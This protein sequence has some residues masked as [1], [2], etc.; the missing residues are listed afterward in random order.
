VS[1]GDRKEFLHEVKL[2]KNLRSEYTMSLLA[3]CDEPGRMCYVMP[4]MQNGDLRRY[5]DEHPLHAAQQHHIASGIAKGL[6]YLHHNG[7]VHRD[8][9]SA[10]VLLDAHL[11]P[12]M[13]DFGLSNRDGQTN[14]SLNR[15]TDDIQWVAPEVLQGQRPNR[16]SDVYSFGTVLWELFTGQKPF[17]NIPPHELMRAAAVRTPYQETLPDSIPPFYK[18]LI[19]RCWA[20]PYHRP[21]MA[22]V[23][24][25]LNTYAKARPELESYHSLPLGQSSAGPASSTPPPLGQSASGFFGPSS[26]KALPP[27]PGA[28]PASPIIARM[29]ELPSLQPPSTQEELADNLF[30]A[31]CEHERQQQL[32]KAATCYQQA[33]HLGHMRAKTNLGS[34]Y[35]EGKGNLPQDFTKAAHLFEEAAKLGHPRAM[36]NLSYCYETGQGVPQNPLKASEW[37]AKASAPQAQ[38][39]SP[40]M[41]R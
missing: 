41:R 25:T 26:S 10:N 12:K 8:V 4:Y 1:E 17:A 29:P 19:A 18:A 16:A 37:K 30:A 21:H 31:G 28:G 7:I 33:S 39:P 23:V 34:F 2:M 3:A 15:R 40:A 5:L 9:K 22:E 14:N 36:Q 24:E 13:A 35:F 6:L 27:I 11:H 38:V 20:A 32:A